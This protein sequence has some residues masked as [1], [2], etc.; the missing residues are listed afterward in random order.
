MAE[1][2][3]NDMND[4]FSD[5]SYREYN[6]LLHGSYIA[7]LMERTMQNM[8]NTGVDGGDSASKSAS[9]LTDEL[10]RVFQESQ[11]ELEWT[12]LIEEEHVVEQEEAQPTPSASKKKS[13]KTG[14]LKKPTPHLDDFGTAPRDL[15]TS[16]DFGISKNDTSTRDA[17]IL[18]SDFGTTSSLVKE[19]IIE[20]DFGDNDHMILID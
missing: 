1:V 16:D 15:P 11:A 20:D 5:S 12:P 9:T 6:R 19:S 7:A 4:L 2:T 10:K 17:R 18:Y 8:H 14:G 3:D 13:K